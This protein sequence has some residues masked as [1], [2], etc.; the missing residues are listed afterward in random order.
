MNK[1]SFFS[2]LRIM[3]VLAV[4]CIM[5]GTASAALIAHYK[6]DETTG[7][8]AVDSGTLA[9]DGTYTGS[10]TLGVAS[11]NAG[12]YGTAVD[13][14][15]PTG[16]VA[17]PGGASSLSQLVDNFTVAAWAN[18]TVENGGY[19]PILSLS[20]WTKSGWTLTFQG[21]KLT[22]GAYGIAEYRTLAGSPVLI[23]PFE[24][25]PG[26]L[27]TWK[28][29]A[30]SYSWTNKEVKLYVNG[31]LANTVII[32]TGAGETQLQASTSPYHLGAWSPYFGITGGLDDVRVYDTLLSP[33]AHLALAEIPEPSSLVLM[34]MGLIGLVSLALARRRR[35]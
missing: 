2:C 10:P 31:T 7:T 23:P 14:V 35:K 6:L 32:D 4:V 30:A 21:P 15:G 27:G 12:L 24:E 22:F 13:F 1:S 19:Q 34:G 8:N 9:N 3:V 11:V 5:T 25:E 26:N 33:E 29:V 20:D 18:P 28:H 16:H 17:I